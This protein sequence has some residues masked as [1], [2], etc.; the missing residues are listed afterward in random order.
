L[1]ASLRQLAP[2]AISK[3][4]S[5]TF[6]VFDNE[7]EQR[8][9]QIFA[10]DVAPRS[11]ITGEFNSSGVLTYL[12]PQAC[13]QD[14]ALRRAYITLGALHVG[15]SKE[16]SNSLALKE[17]DAKDV[18]KYALQQYQQAIKAMREVK[19]VRTALLSCIL[20]FCIEMLVRNVELAFCQV[21]SGLKLLGHY[22][23]D[24]SN[25][26]VSGLEDDIINAFR[27]LEIRK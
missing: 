24:T 21:A 2:A 12:I 26:P 7:L 10:R 17:A 25:T 18:Y 6:H 9:F 8:Y 22:D 27:T 3:G 19:D 13:W 5:T 4:P 1:N 16:L 14:P 20:I 23:A 11:T 15:R